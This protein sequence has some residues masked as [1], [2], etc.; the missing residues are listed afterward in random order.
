MRLPVHTAALRLL[1]R[2]REDGKKHTI[3]LRTASDVFFQCMIDLA[4]SDPL[5]IEV[6]GDHVSITPEGRAVCAKA[7]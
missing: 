3:D 4:A 1:N 5:L 7:K 6:D 2:T